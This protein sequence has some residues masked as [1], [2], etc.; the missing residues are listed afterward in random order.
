MTS[1]RSTE[2]SERGG[3]TTRSRLTPYPTLLKRYAATIPL[4]VALY[5]LSRILGALYDRATGTVSHELFVPVLL[6]LMAFGLT[7]LLSPSLRGLV[8]RPRK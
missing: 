4:G 1:A 3:G 6:V 7:M 8:F 5:A 2:K